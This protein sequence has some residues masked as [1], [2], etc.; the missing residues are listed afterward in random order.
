MIGTTQEEVPGARPWLLHIDGS[1]TAQGNGADI[2]L[3]T[4]QGD[5]MEFAIK[6]E[7]K[8]SNNEAEYKV[9]VLYMRMAQDAGVSHLLAYYDSQLVVRQVN[10]EDEAKEESMVQ[11]LQQIKEL[12]TSFKSFQL[13]QISIEENIK[14]D[15]LS[16]LA[17]ALKDCKTRRITVQH[18][19]QPRIPLAIQPVSSSNNDWRTPIIRWIDEGHLPEDRWE[20]TKIKNRA[21]H[22]L[23]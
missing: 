3:T 10:G 18:L 15:S 23:I 22:F 11:N 19:P 16:K 2:M 20:A 1:S 21:I 9:M 5:D 17:S 12:K 6:F 7:F 4:P 13:H 8:V 14:T